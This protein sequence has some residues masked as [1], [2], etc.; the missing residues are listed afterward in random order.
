MTCRCYGEHVKKREN[1]Y[2]WWLVRIYNKSAS[3]RSSTGPS[4]VVFCYFHLQTVKVYSDGPPFAFLFCIIDLY[5]SGFKFSIIATESVISLGNI[6]IASGQSMCRAPLTDVFHG[7][8]F[9]LFVGSYSILIHRRVRLFIVASLVGRSL[10][11]GSS[12]TILVRRCRSLQA[13]YKPF[14]QFN[15]YLN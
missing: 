13:L 9:F 5:F 4:V 7:T 2:R 12:N 15:G 14:L 10:E 6:H 3:T 1:E 8:V 11:I